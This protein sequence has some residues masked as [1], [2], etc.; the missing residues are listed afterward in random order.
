MKGI[1]PIVS[2]VLL[3]AFTVTVAVIIGS[4]YRNLAKTSAETVKEQTTESLTCTYGGINLYDVKFSSTTN[5]VNGKIKNTGNVVL[6]DVDIQIFYVNGSSIV[7]EKNFTMDP[8]EII[9]FNVSSG[10]SSLSE[11]DFVRVK[12]N[13]SNV[14]AKV[15]S[16]KITIT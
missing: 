14:D 5:Y 15:E 12:T 13:C 6:G 10:C 16:S 11:I 3:I 8:G 1:S 2:S 4:W 7:Y 9:G